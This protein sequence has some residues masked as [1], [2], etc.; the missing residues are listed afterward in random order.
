VVPA[1]VGTDTL[2]K[3]PNAAVLRAYIFAAMP[4]WK[5]GSLTEEETLQITAFLLRQNNLWSAQ[6]DITMDNAAT[7]PVGPPPATATPQ[8]GFFPT[9]ISMNYL[10]LIVIGVVVILLLVLQKRYRKSHIES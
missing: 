6:Q 5:P 4:F 10:P 3:F 2:Q 8:P 1:L 9:S 7:I